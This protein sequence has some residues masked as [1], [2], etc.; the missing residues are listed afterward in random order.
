MYYIRV[1]GKNGASDPQQ[2][3]SLV[4][5]NNVKTPPGGTGSKPNIN[6]GI[7]KPTSPEL[8]SIYPNP[9]QDFLTINYTSA[10][11]IA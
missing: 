7:L 4:V 8:F 2:N 5:N 6:N 3:Y 11:S 10:H 9:A 1:F